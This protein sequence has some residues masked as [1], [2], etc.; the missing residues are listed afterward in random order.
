MCSDENNFS[1]IFLLVR[2]RYRLEVI[3]VSDGMEYCEITKWKGGVKIL[4]YSIN[5]WCLNIR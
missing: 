4:N 1:A 5:P 3:T 2:C